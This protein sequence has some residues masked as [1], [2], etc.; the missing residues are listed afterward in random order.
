MAGHVRPEKVLITGGRGYLGSRIGQFLSECD[1]QVSLGSREPLKNGEISNCRQVVTNWQDPTLAFCRGYDLI[2]HAAGMNARDCAESPDSAFEFNGLLTEKLVKHA[3]KDGCKRFFYLS[4]VHVYD[5]PLVGCFSE[6]SAILNFHPYATS[7]FYGEQALVRALQAG[8]IEGAVLR[9]SNCFG[10]S[11]VKSKDY[12]ELVL[13]QFV[14]DAV[15]KSV[16]TVKGN[17]LSQRDFL[18]ISALN[19]LIKEVLNYKNPLSNTINISS[20]EARTLEE[21]ANIVADTVFA[22]TGKNVLIN[23]NKNPVQE[24]D[25]IIK[26]TVLSSMGI[27]VN[28]DVTQEVRALMLDLFDEN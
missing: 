7:H 24:G 16:I 10:S 28:N 9:L 20:G 14:R 3:I 1:Y 11:V 5:S 6:S 15:T 23:K 27:S 13:N 18:P 2:I 8:Q 22:V 19:Q 21:V 26:N 25:L 12:W 4:T 17:Y